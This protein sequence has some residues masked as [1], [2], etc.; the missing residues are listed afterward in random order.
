[1]V[2]G[3]RLLRADWIINSQLSQPNDHGPGSMSSMLSS[4]EDTKSFEEQIGVSRRPA[5]LLV[6]N[7]IGRRQYPLERRRVEWRGQWLGRCREGC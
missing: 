5:V 1:M 3:S 4:E 2:Y 6:T 7:A